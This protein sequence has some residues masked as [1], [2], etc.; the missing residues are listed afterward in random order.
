MVAGALERWGEQRVQGK[1]AEAVLVCCIL[2]LKYS[3]KL[4]VLFLNITPSVSTQ[5]ATTK[6]FKTLFEIIEKFQYLF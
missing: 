2:N 1:A 4:C 3:Y 6:R 5:N